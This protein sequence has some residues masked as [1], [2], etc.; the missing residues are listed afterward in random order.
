MSIISDSF[1][2]EKRECVLITHLTLFK[3]RSVHHSIMYCVIVFL[4][5]QCFMR[6]MCNV[7]KFECS[8]VPGL[9]M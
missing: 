9:M 7:C 8:N 5:N 3:C 6:V 1:N 2:L 4:I